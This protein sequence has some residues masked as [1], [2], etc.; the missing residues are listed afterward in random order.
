MQLAC[1]LA[2]ALHQ[3]HRHHPVLLQ[4]KGSQVWVHL[5]SFS[6]NPESSFGGADAAPVQSLL[7]IIRLLQLCHHLSTF[8]L[9]SWASSSSQGLT[10]PGG[11]APRGH[12]SS[13]QFW[14]TCNFPLI[15][16]FI[17]HRLPAVGSVSVWEDIFLQISYF[18]I[19]KINFV[20]DLCKG[21][22]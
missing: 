17:F 1:D 16:L 5:L 12:R 19:K 20:P 9:E 2:S 22:D 10:S 8:V 15:R 6:A 4:L 21:L 3:E 14:P 13:L 18:I 7:H 11:S